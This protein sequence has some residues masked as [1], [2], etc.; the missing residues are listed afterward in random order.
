MPP[1]CTL[2][3]HVTASASAPQ[4]NETPDSLDVDGMIGAF[5]VKC[6]LQM[7]YEKNGVCLLSGVETLTKMGRP[8]WI[9]EFACVID[10]TP[11]PSSFNMMSTSTSNAENEKIENSLHKL[12]TLTNNFDTIV[13]GTRTYSGKTT[14][15]KMTVILKDK[16]GNYID[17]NGLDFDV[18]MEIKHL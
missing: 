9:Y 3:L 18:T 15:Q 5:L 13:A 1:L 16:F 8:E 10:S 17:L 4:M 11:T 6:A 12:R 7:H 2:H 14:L